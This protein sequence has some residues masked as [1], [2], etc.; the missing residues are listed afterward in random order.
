MIKY[1]LKND[2]TFVFRYKKKHLI[3]YFSIILVFILFQTK[4]NLINAKELYL[5]SLG[6]DASFEKNFISILV[7]LYHNIII[8]YFQFLLFTKDLRNGPENL[9]LRVKLRKWY[10]VK[11]LSITLFTLSIKFILHFFVTILFYFIYKNLEIRICLY[12]K[13]LLFS[14]IYTLIIQNILMFLYFLKNRIFKFTL[15]FITIVYSILKN[16]SLSVIIA[17]KNIELALLVLCVLFIGNIVL[18]GIKYLSVFEKE[19]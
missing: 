18:F 14:L 17:I 9:F 7:F 11:I 10:F 8:I 12:F 15:L 6:L 13:Y 3:L 1:S 2:C 16:M 5:D 4:I 19:V